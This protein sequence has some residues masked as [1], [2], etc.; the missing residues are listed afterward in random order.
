MRRLALVLAVVGLAACDRPPQ[1]PDKTAPPEPQVAARAL[2][3]PLDRAAA[4]QQTLDTA[5]ETREVLT[6]AAGG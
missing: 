6:T 5:A 1:P 3:A 2:Q 4:V